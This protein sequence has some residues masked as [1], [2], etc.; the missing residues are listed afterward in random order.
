MIGRGAA[1]GVPVP[2]G[3]G[4]VLEV[5]GGDSDLAAAAVR[6]PE[7]SL[8]R[9]L[10]DPDADFAR[11]LGIGPGGGPGHTMAVCDLL[12][13]GGATAAVNAV[14]S[15]VAPDR[16]RARH[17]RRP[18][19]VE[20]DGRTVFDGC[21]TTVV[22][23]NGQ[24]LRGADLVPRGHPGDGRAEVQVYALPRGER[25]ALRDRLRTGGHVPHPRIT[26]AS[27]ARIVL[28]WGR[29][30]MPF[31]VDGRPGRPTPVIEVAVRQG[32]LRVRI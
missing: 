5:A 20:V 13:L 4:P 2:D 31:E 22:V 1:W 26:Q 7:G 25:R 14:V 23:A 15:G 10:P 21:A 32:A 6:A 19:R 28:R 16:L 24:F 27:G 12:D 29:G 3:A 9:F 11:A 30:A 8:L 17:R 18:V